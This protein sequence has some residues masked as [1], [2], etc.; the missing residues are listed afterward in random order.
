MTKKVI[1]FI[2]LL[3]FLPYFAQQAQQQEESFIIAAYYPSPYGMYNELRA[4]KMVIGDINSAT[5]P[6]PSD[7]AITF[8]PTSQPSN[9]S[10]G[11]LYF[12]NAVGKFKYYDGTWKEL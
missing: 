12:D 1:V 8:M 11:T 4:T 7:G 5:T 9:Y 2:L 10:R 3:L 6:T